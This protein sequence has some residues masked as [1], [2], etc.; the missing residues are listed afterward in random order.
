VPKPSPQEFSLLLQAWSQGNKSALDRLI[1]MVYDELHRLAHHYL[2]ME[3]AGH[4]LQ[5]SAL[6][7]EAYIRLV[8]ASRMH[9]RDR[10]HFF[11][12]AAKLMRQILVDFARKRSYQKRASGTQE[13]SLD[14][15][16]AVG[17]ASEEN[18]LRL[19]EATKALAEFDA[20]KAKVVELRFFGGLNV[21][22][23]AEV[24]N[25]ARITVIRDWK[26]AKLWL[27]RE[28]RRG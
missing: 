19:D 27:L 10:A 2:A 22:E 13:L 28:L 4:S 8:D 15:P 17:A 26:M 21:E 11:G 5:T 3:K 14:D 16:L 6:V 23:T 1:P 24:L 12:I 7:N 9:W 18:I 20:R 25:V